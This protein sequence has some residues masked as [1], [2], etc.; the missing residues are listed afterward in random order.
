MGAASLF[1]ELG[2]GTWTPTAWAEGVEGA[3]VGVLELRR[4]FDTALAVR[5]GAG[6]DVALSDGAGDS[7]AT[8]EADLPP[9]VFFAGL[10]QRQLHF[11]ALCF[12]SQ[13]NQIM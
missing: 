11:K 8:G 12:S 2:A 9:G 4:E 3:G 13:H 10:Q 1:E 7:A 6:T 5:L